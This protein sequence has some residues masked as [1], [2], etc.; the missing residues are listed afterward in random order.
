MRTW[1]QIR[2]P[3][4]VSMNP[5]KK[6][7]DH[8]ICKLWLLHQFYFA[9]VLIITTY[10]SIQCYQPTP[11]NTS[12]N[13]TLL[14]T[15]LKLYLCSYSDPTLNW[16]APPKDCVFWYFL[17][18]R[19]MCFDWEASRSARCQPSPTYLDEEKI[20]WIRCATTPFAKGLENFLFI[21]FVF[22]SD[23]VWNLTYVLSLIS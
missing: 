12:E 9:V 6:T 20:K 10:L 23:E 18:K 22:F 4:Y 3:S 2:L 1:M 21:A 19:K 15:G 11:W 13:L 16:K 8:F 7:K 14:S 17:I 5:R